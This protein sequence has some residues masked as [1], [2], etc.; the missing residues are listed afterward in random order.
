MLEVSDVH[1]VRI[2]QSTYP[3]E[4]TS[5][6]GPG[7]T[8]GRRTEFA[9]SRTEGIHQ[10]TEGSRQQTARN[11]RQWEGGPCP[12]VSVVS[13]NFSQVSVYNSQLTLHFRGRP[14]TW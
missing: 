12:T 4:E 13:I 7:R 6:W 14:L 2:H 9:G 5:G 10:Q 3:A 1:S 8:A 11:Q